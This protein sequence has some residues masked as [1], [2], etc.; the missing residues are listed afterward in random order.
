MQNTNSFVFKM[1][2]Y[3]FSVLK[4]VV[5][6]RSY[7]VGCIFVDSRQIHV[8]RHSFWNFNYWFRGSVRDGSMLQR[9]KGLITCIYLTSVRNVMITVSYSQK[10]C[11]SLVIIPLLTFGIASSRTKFLSYLHSRD[12]FWSVFLCYLSYEI[13]FTGIRTRETRRVGS[14]RH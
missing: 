13:P 9:M 3:Y 11:K 1:L 6:W 12:Y 4:P 14:R 2:Y 10:K 7:V 8:L 5:K